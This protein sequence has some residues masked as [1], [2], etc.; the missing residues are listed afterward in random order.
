ME[1]AHS[2]RKVLAAA[3]SHFS[4]HVDSTSN[5]SNLLLA[6]AASVHR[7][8]PGGNGATLLKSPPALPFSG[9]G[10]SKNVTLTKPSHITPI[11]PTPLIL[12]NSRTSSAD[13]LSTANILPL[14]TPEMALRMATEVAG[15]V[16]P[17]PPQ[18]PQVLVKQGVSKC[19]E[20]NIV[21]CK[22][23]NYM[24]HKKHYCS[25]RLEGGGDDGGSVSSPQ[26][27]GGVPSSP[28]GN[29]P[30]GGS[31]PHGKDRG[32]SASPTTAGSSAQQQQGQ[33]GQK[34]PTLFQFI[35]VAC[36]IKFTSLDNLT[37]HQAY[38]C[39][40]R[41]ELINKTSAEAVTD[42]TSISS[43]RKCMKC[44]VSSVCCISG[45][46]TLQLGFYSACFLC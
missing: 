30:N 27:G 14:L 2:Q 31:P 24:A 26:G 13:L 8:D 28:S 44:K 43:S 1:S 46:V 7:E 42:K 11:L 20:C 35:C 19:R 23:E 39:P 29:T 3:L 41:S 33:T 12:P 40:K 4:S 9:K 16:V 37:A 5:L 10:L 15:V 45:F 32:R 17:P 38:Y 18:P 22:H 25:A 36:G 21:F 34:P 6:V